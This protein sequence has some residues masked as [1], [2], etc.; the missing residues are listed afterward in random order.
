MLDYRNAAEAVRLMNGGA[1]GAETLGKSPVLMQA[2]LYMV[3]A[4]NGQPLERRVPNAR[5][6]AVELGQIVASRP[7]MDDEDEE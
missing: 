3:R 4:Q 2:M 5:A 7:Q 6:D 1:T